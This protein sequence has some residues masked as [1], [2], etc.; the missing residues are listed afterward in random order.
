MLIHIRQKSVRT[1]REFFLFICVILLLSGMVY[2][3]YQHQAESSREAA[4]ASALRGM[5]DLSRSLFEEIRR[6]VGDLRLIRNFT[7]LSYPPDRDVPDNTLEKLEAICKHVTDLNPHYL[8]IDF[9]E[10]PEASFTPLVP[11]G[12][13]HREREG[14]W[15]G[16]RLL[17][18]FQIEIGGRERLI[19]LHYAIGWSFTSLSRRYAHGWDEM[20]L[21]LGNGHW[22]RLSEHRLEADG[23]EAEEEPEGAIPGL[24]AGNDFEMTFPLHA[25]L[26]EGR[27]AGGIFRDVGLF[28]FQT[29][30]TASLGLAG[31]ERLWI[32]SFMKNWLVISRVPPLYLSHGVQ[33]LRVFLFILWLG[34]LAAA[35]IV[36]FRRRPSAFVSPVQ[37]GRDCPA[38]FYY[39][40]FFEKTGE[41]ILV[42]RGGAIIFSNAQSRNFLGR[43]QEELMNAPL[44]ILFHSDDREKAM[45]FYTCVKTGS[46]RE[47]MGNPFAEFRLDT[48]P[49]EEK[50]VE[51]HA[52]WLTW[53]EE[54][55]IFLFF[56]D[57]TRRK[58]NEQALQ[59]ANE[60][61]RELSIRDSL[62]QVYN[63]RHMIDI[64]RQEFERSRR[65]HHEL[66]CILFDLDYFKE[67]NDTMGH[68]FGDQVLRNFAE[69]LRGNIRY[70]DFIFRYGG[71]EFLI[72]LPNTDGD[73]ALA[74]AEKIRSNWET[75]STSNGVSSISITVSAGV[76]SR[77][78]NRPADWQALVTFADRALYQAKAEG[79][80][81]SAIYHKEPGRLFIRDKQKDISYLKER[82]ATIL[83]KTKR[84]SVESI[85]LLVRDMGGSKYRKHA[86]EVNHFLELLAGRLYLPPEVI[87][88]FK[89]ASSIHNCFKVLLEKTV[90]KDRSLTPEEWEEIEAHPY[91]LAE[92]TE[93]FDFFINERAVLLYHHEC[94]D[95]SGY[96]EGLKGEEIPL[97]ARIFAV[98]DAIVAMMSDRPYRSKLP[99]EKLMDELVRHA[100]AQFDPAIVSICLTIVEEKQLLN[101][102]P[103]TIKN[104]RKKLAQIQEQ[105]RHG[106][107]GDNTD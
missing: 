96:P 106:K 63:R 37:S 67:V 81:R 86:L 19:L 77:V 58:Q 85:E 80:N 102:T 74:A 44:Q 93:L 101:I 65:Y 50:W 48:G 39:E 18:P 83:D 16:R 23:D 22:L 46:A 78:K 90:E 71:E 41:T 94:Y 9:R 99:P 88:T 12:I 68:V 103:D 91:V 79:R 17:I 24:S 97:G 43:S 105:L 45:E 49:G 89:R 20:F 10:Q 33:G 34:L 61:L 56:M 52:N 30:E 98:A 15:D 51:I 35:T 84:A 28:T 100:G 7:R 5:E 75:F 32:R 66:S 40:A 36:F 13:S 11:A 4:S 73:G 14:A 59:Q 107:K 38:R 62:T 21:V 31:D 2:L 3:L 8:K 42:T 70:P 47:E 27:R 92:L 72:L 69:F 53:D 54:D 104:A 82:L 60:Q 57:I 26:P 25:S 6:I 64:L 87:D 76:S 95:G 55:A 1:G 29:V